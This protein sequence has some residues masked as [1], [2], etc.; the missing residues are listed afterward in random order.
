MK[1]ANCSRVQTSGRISLGDDVMQ[2]LELKVGD[3][4]QLVID[5]KT[6]EV[7]LQKITP[8]I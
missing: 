5:S 8:S 6:S 1:T 7:R 2:V 4:V 3:F